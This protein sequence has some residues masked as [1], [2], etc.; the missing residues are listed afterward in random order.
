MDAK[1][2]AGPA[3]RLPLPFSVWLMKHTM[4]G[5]PF[6]RPW[7]ELAAITEQFDMT[8][9]LFRAYYICRGIKP[10]DEFTEID[11]AHRIA[12]E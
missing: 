2:S 9:H 12:A 4:L 3:A 10:E 5:N 1:L 11:I 6:I 8:E 7:Q